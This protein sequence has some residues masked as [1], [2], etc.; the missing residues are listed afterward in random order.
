M[1]KY[2]RDWRETALQKNAYDTAAFVGDKLVAL[3]SVHIS[4]PAPIQACKQLTIVVDRRSLRYLGLSTRPLHCG[5]LLARPEPPT[6]VQQLCLLNSYL[7]DS[8]VTAT[9]SSTRCKISR[10]TM[11]HPTGPTRRSSRLSRREEPSP[12]RHNPEF[13]EKETL[14]S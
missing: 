3:T 2:L 13:C 10:C 14:A 11:L 6:Q 12:P 7:H 1:E 9:S 4:P 5:Q 8:F